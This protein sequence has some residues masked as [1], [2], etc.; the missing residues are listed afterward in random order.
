MTSDDA[1]PGPSIRVTLKGQNNVTYFGTLTFSPNWTLFSEDSEN[2]T[3]AASSTKDYDQK[4]ASYYV[5]AV[6]LVYGMSIV[7]L[8]ASHIKRRQEKLQE[9]KQI[10]KYLQDFQIVK[11]RHA[12]DSYKNLKRTIMTKINWDRH[13]KPTYHTLQRSLIPLLAIGMPGAQ[14]L[15][16]GESLS[17]SLSNVDL[18]AA[19]QYMIAKDKG[20]VIHSR[21]ASHDLTAAY[22]AAARRVSRD[23]TPQLLA[24]LYKERGGGGGSGGGGGARGPRGGEHH[25]PGGS[26]QLY[27]GSH[28]PLLRSS[29][30]SRAN[31]WEE[32]VIEEPEPD[33]PD[34]VPRDPQARPQQPQHP[35]N[36]QD[37]NEAPSN[38]HKTTPPNRS[39]VTVDIT[40]MN[41]TTAKRLSA[42]KTLH[43]NSPTSPQ[44]GLHVPVVWY[45]NPLVPRGCSPSPTE[46][47]RNYPGHASRK[48]PAGSPGSRAGTPRSCPGLSPS[49]P[50]FSPSSPSLSPSFLGRSPSSPRLSGL[51][52]VLT[53]GSREELIQVTCV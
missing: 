24:R 27:P 37:Q 43:L 16:E 29:W 1:M 7:M 9:D 41:C 25:G 28:L 36:D 39:Q 33:S 23:H 38:D 52:P 35:I 14:D 18:A 2:L 22:F 21:K 49:S 40:P 34:P 12:R 8:I 45:S 4:G 47:L 26:H 50:G 42:P 19:E 17:S 53:D 20:K 44:R 48:S 46:P 51:S 32:T 15:A 3:A 5:I 10:N 30:G 31:S 11:E 6:V 13:K